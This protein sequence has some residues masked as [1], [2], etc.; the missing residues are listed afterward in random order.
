MDNQ[1]K[2][3]I[4]MDSDESAQF[5]TN[6]SGWVS[7]NGRY[8]GDD[9]RTARYDGCTHRKCEKCGKVIVKDYIIC[10]DCH[11]LNLK[12][13]FDSLPKVKWDGKGGLYSESVDKFFWNWGEVDEYSYESQISKK[14]L[15]LVI[16]EPVY[17]HLLDSDYGCDEL[18]EDGELPDQVIKAIEDF[19]K[20]IK[21]TSPVSWIPSNKAVL[22]EE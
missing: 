1:V 19:N 10:D 13:K 14:D 7:R 5:K 12:A 6:L 3:I 8:F 20:V 9:E 22:I 16:C 18:P 15:R 2:N 4:L 21:D 17:L 11:Q